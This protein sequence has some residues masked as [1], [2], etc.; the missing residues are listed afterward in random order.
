MQNNIN[1][2]NNNCL[3]KGNC[4][5]FK[6]S[7]KFNSN[8]NKRTMGNNNL[9]HKSR[10]HDDP[11]YKNLRT[12]QS[13]GP[14]GYQINNHYDCDTTIKDT[15]NNATEN[16]VTNFKNGYDVGCNAIDDSSK[17]RIGASRKFPRC[18][19]QL[20]TRPYLTVPYMGKGP[21]N[22]ELE[23]QIN[24]GET[25]KVKR[26]VNTLSGVTI[27]HYFTPLVPHL[28]HNIQNPKH[29]VQESVDDGWVRGGSNTRLIIRDEDY[30]TRCGYNYMNKETNSYFWKNK[31][32]YL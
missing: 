4:I 14:G 18:P 27:P 26:S 23:S 13:M 19:N 25:T 1:M 15:V 24:P 32:N 30:L 20:F 17:L 2:N 9:Y 31:H 7:E 12:L 6:K 11:C 28:E 16:V 3:N 22:M 10:S 8:G 5:K 21:G 29:I